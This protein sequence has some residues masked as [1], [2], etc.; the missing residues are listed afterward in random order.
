MVTKKNSNFD[1]VSVNFCADVDHIEGSQQSNSVF[2]S[3]SKDQWNDNGFRV[4]INFR[5]HLQDIPEVYEGSGYIGFLQKEEDTSYLKKL[6]NDSELIS[7]LAG[8]QHR[9]FTMLPDMEAYRSLVRA[10]T[11][12]NAVKV[13]KCMRD[14]VAL[15]EFRTTANW[16]DDAKLSRV[17]TQAFLRD[18]GAYFAFKNAGSI[19]RNLRSEDLGVL[20]KGFSINFKMEGRENEHNL[21]FVFDHGD[22]LPKRIAVV[23]GRNGVGKSQALRQISESLL[24]GKKNIVDIVDGQRPSINR[25]LVFS[26]TN[27]A[28]TVFPTGRGKNL[29]WYRRFSLNRSLKKRDGEAVSDLIV[30]LARSDQTIGRSSR[31]EIFLR[32]LAAIERSDELC[33]LR[34]EKEDSPIPIHEMRKGGSF[35]A[36]DRYG[37]INLKADPVRIVNEKIFPLSSGEISFLRFASQVSLYVENGSLLLLDEPE[38]HLHPAFISQLVSLL[39][40]LLDAT[41]SAAIIATHSVY[42]V[43]EVFSEQVTVLT[44]NRNGVVGSKRPNL[45]TFG[46]DVGAI[47]YFVF[48][49]DEPS[50]LAKRVKGKLINKFSKWDDV[51][52]KYKR[53]LSP[54]LLASLRDSMIRKSEDEQD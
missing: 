20:T 25:L 42:F 21:H 24:K 32:G 2:I 45:N 31:W 9:F 26:P 50:Q 4:R 15:N 6:L 33:L 51:Y 38:T 13:L 52:T 53:E 49:E 30:Q 5:I 35:S 14:M 8:D 29:I 43:R 17:F 12:K 48:D 47:S 1:F 16:V 19:L 7:V 46:A 41:G 28:A 34:R 44:V 10:L 36:L 37:E 3:I 39:D 27:E 18:Y 22:D 11:P 23:I 54:D 40:R